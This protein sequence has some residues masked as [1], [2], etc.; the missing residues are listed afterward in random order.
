MPRPLTPDDVDGAR[1]EPEQRRRLDDLIAQIHAVMP[2][3]AAAAI[4]QVAL[5]AFRMTARRSGNTWIDVTWFR[6]SGGTGAVVRTPA[7]LAD[8]GLL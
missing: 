8:D 4:L 5:D 7:S 6:L 3:R 1:L 2:S